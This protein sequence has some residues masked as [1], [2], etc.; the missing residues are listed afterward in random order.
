MVTVENENGAVLG[1]GLV[2]YSAEELGR[3]Q[4]HRTSRIHTQL[5]YKTYDEVIHRDNLV[6]MEEHT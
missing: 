3:I 1:Q 5:G 2:N 4:G 6:V